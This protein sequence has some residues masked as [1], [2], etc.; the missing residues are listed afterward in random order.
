MRVHRQM[1]WVAAA[2]GVGLAASIVLAP[3]AAAEEVP[4][5]PGVSSV[6]QVPDRGGPAQAAHPDAA[7]YARQ[8]PGSVPPGI[9][10][11]TCTPT[12]GH[13]RPVVLVHGTDSN[14]YSDWAALGPRL[15][16][17]GYCV[18]ALN[19]GGKP[20]G[21]N[22]GTEDMAVSAGQLAQFV[23]EVRG[24]TGAD[25]V[26]IVG[27]S[28]GSTVAR[29]YVNRL[30]GAAAVDQWVGLASPTYGGTMFGLVPVLEQTPGG[31]E[32]A[33]AAL[34]PE[35]VSPALE[36]QAQGSPF[37][38]DLN[39]GADTVPGTRYTTIGSRLDEVIQPATNIALHDR[40]ATNLMI[41]DLCPINQSGH[42]R[43]PYDEYTLQLV[44]G[45][46]DP[47]MPPAPPCTAVPAGTGILEM[48]LTENF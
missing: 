36:Q 8:H 17:A 11:F 25:E 7:R 27:Y 18:F 14:A 4:D 13:P 33:T 28:Q 44:M 32:L 24:A 38:D 39:G 30:G 34:P 41:Q 2:A 40:S 16:G 37:L 19:Y 20:G 22:Y 9:N 46:L 21:D 42:F 10:D 31:M 35:L 48:I 43:M 5:V 45:V 12:G 47:T 3:V 1:R 15:A 23:A 26:D 6:W 29:Y